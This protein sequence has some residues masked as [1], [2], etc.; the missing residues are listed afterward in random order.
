MEDYSNPNLAHQK[1]NNFCIPRSRTMS[2]IKGTKELTNQNLKMA[3]AS[4]S[5][6][7]TYYSEKRGLCLKKLLSKR[8]F[9]KLEI[10]LEYENPNFSI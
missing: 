2:Q 3:A 8:N 5:N 10:F 9:S 4:N 6:A 1:E 7:V